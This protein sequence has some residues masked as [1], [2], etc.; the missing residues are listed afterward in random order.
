MQAVSKTR[1]RISPGFSLLLF[2]M[3]ILAVSL[4]LGYHA[5]A[6]ARSHKESAEN[7]LRDYASVAAWQYSSL[8][9]ENLSELLR[10]VFED[11]TL[12]WSDSRRLSPVTTLADETQHV[13]RWYDCECLEIRHPIAFFRVDLRDSTITAY[14]DTISADILSR[15]AD[16]LTTYQSTHAENRTGLMLLPPGS[17][18]GSAT[19]IT[20]STAYTRRRNAAGLFGFV[21]TP[22]A[23]AELLA[24]WFNAQPLLSPAVSDSRSNDSLLH[25]SVRI[26]GTTTL[27]ESDGAVPSSY[28]VLDSMGSEHGGLLI[29]A[30]IRP[31]VADQLIIGGLPRSRLPLILVL[32]LLTIALGAASLLQLRR[33]H[34][35]ARLREDFVSG[36]SHELRTPLAQVRMFAELLESGRLRTDEEHDRS[37][38]VI[39]R[40]ARRLTHLVDNILQ[41]SR[42]GRAAVDLK[43]ESLA[44]GAL[45]QEV[46]EAFGPLALARSNALDLHF[47]PGLW[48][49]ADRDALSQILLNLLDNAVKYGPEGQ[50]VRI[51]AR[52]ADQMLRISVEDEG[53]G[54]PEHERQRIWEPYRRLQRDP[55][56]PIT[57]TGI[58]LAVVRELVELHDGS[59]WVEAT[60]QGGARFV[61]ELP[62]VT[63]VTVENPVLAAGESV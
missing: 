61:V 30:A 1:R 56:H 12:R 10:D 5:L 25:V 32:L 21:T 43:I 46:L 35:L 7:A 52:R 47:A 60:E 37:L 42:S 38:S 14:P 39:N 55:Q 50:T 15:L 34:Q 53:L 58:G 27:F 6:T 54:I 17:V 51:A 11:V 8:A 33:E 59:A 44:V 28:S 45:L 16:T 9:R 40:E 18:L 3:A 57:G 23:Y 24:Q 22:S 41:F 48:I 26:G 19:L 63:E 31:E 36:V 2:L 4:G 20:Y 13:S 49:R 62:G 29:E